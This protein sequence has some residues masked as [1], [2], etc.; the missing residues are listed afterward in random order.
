MPARI[1]FDHSTIAHR[2]LSA[3]QTLEFATAHNLDGVQFL[4]P[5][6]IDRELDSNR[7]ATFRQVASERGLYLEIGMSSPN[8]VRSA[9]ERGQGVSAAEHASALGRE[10]EAVLALGCTR[11]H[12]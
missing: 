6:E 11:E 8:P 12:H 3:E 7:L 5:T 1:G 4:E 9:R 2:G 10:F